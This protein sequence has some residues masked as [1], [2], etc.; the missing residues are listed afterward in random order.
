MLLPTDGKGATVQVCLSA[1]SETS[2][3]INIVTVVTT[4]EMHR[5]ETVKT[6]SCAAGLAP[7][8]HDDAT[9]AWNV[10]I[11]DPSLAGSFPGRTNHPGASKKKQSA[12]EIPP[13]CFALTVGKKSVLMHVRPRHMHI[14]SVLESELTP[15][16]CQCAMHQ[17]AAA[18]DRY[19]WVETLKSEITDRMRSTDEKSGGSTQ[20]V[21][22][23]TPLL[24]LLSLTTI[25]R[26]FTM[27]RLALASLWIFSE[28][29]SQVPFDD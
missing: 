16:M 17:A 20:L 24:Y 3:T 18:S 13:N 29:L 19:R 11:G 21:V 10:E 1:E 8:V 26:S 23:P 2:C 12:E 7:Q 6:H 27:K 14:T 25:R 22:N 9:F 15:S 5:A 28:F 4:T